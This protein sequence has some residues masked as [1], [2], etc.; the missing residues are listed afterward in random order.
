MNNFNTII[1]NGSTVKIGSGGLK[2]T[3]VGVCMRG[4]E[5]MTIEYHVQWV[6]SGGVHSEWL[7]DYMVS[8]FIDTSRPAGMVN[9]ETSLTVA[10]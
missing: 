4:V 5:N 10:K 2:A 8:E 6:D 3:V 9:Y 1:K 7:Y